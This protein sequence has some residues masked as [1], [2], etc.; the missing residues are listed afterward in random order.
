MVTQ[1]FSNIWRLIIPRGWDQMF[2]IQWV[3]KENKLL[4]SVNPAKTAKRVMG[5]VKRFLPFNVG[6]RSA[7]VQPGPAQ[8]YTCPLICPQLGLDCL[9]R[10]S[11]FK[12]A[13]DLIWQKRLVQSRHSVNWQGQLMLVANIRMEEG[14]ERG[15]SD[16]REWEGTWGVWAER[17]WRAA[18]QINKF[19]LFSSRF[20]FSLL[21]LIIHLLL[22]F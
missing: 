15:V 11:E 1:H 7:G 8:P 16:L 18:L 17:K 10:F 22:L 4:I 14:L 9:K 21:S 12:C 2:C 3:K 6:Q 19:C 13:T 20:I 5:E